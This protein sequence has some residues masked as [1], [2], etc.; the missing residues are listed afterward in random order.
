MRLCQVVIQFVLRFVR[1]F[2]ISL[3]KGLHGFRNQSGRGRREP[4]PARNSLPGDP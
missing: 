4:S 1:C 3:E 2:Y